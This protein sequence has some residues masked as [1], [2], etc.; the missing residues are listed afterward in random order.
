MMALS[1]AQD[2]VGTVL[3]KGVFASVTPV[4]V[5]SS[6][7]IVAFSIT[8]TLP[9]GLSLNTSTGLISGTPTEDVALTN[10]TIT[11]TDQS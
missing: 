6:I 10:Y 1:I 8:P 9:A 11:V 3:V 7:G 2:F 4:R 5:T